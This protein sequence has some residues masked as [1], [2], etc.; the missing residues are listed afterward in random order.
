MNKIFTGISANLLRDVPFSGIYLFAFENLRTYLSP[1]ENKF[2]R[3]FFC[4]SLGGIIAAFFTMP[5]D[6]IKTRRQVYMM[7]GL[8]TLQFDEAQS[9][10]FRNMNK[11]IT[12]C[13]KRSL[14]P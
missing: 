13:T 9:K 8:E 7:E 5:F 12:N 1:F 4:G 10:T 2:Y 3:D 6:L 14:L 11:T